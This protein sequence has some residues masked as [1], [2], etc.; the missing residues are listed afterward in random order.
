MAERWSREQKIIY[1]LAE[2]IVRLRVDVKASEIAR[3]LADCGVVASEPLDCTADRD[4]LAAGRITLGLLR[5]LFA[6]WSLQNG[7]RSQH[8]QIFQLAF[9]VAGDAEILN[10]CLPNVDCTDEELD[11][12][13]VR[14]R[15]TGTDSHLGIGGPAGLKG[16][17]TVA[18]FLFLFDVRY[19]CSAV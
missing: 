12:V 14:R 3:S 6:L 8:F 2:A 17:T 1:C 11:A 5:R 13:V 10:K 9:K 4:I 15:N 19:L 7:E 16:V 18:L